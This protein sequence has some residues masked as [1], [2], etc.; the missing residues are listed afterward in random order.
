MEVQEKKKLDFVQLLK[1]QGIVILY[2]FVGLLS[3]NAAGVLNEKGLFSWQ[4]IGI[5]AGMFGILMLYAFFWQKI[6]KKIDLSVAYV[7]KGLGILW[8]LLWSIL[9]MKEG[10]LSIP[11]IIGVVLIVAGILVVTKE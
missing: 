5:V 8:S 9:I 2:S 1:I 6:L 11:Q 3:K 10:M 4:F 7:N